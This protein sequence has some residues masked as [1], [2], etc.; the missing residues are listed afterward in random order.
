MP[1][2]AV[3]GEGGRAACSGRSPTEAAEPGHSTGGTKELEGQPE[4]G[5]G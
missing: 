1:A 3:W 5:H 2:Q 4:V